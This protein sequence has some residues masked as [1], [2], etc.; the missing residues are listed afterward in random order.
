[1]PVMFTDRQFDRI[2]MTT[3]ELRKITK[4]IHGTQRITVAQR[5]QLVKIS[6]SLTDRLAEHQR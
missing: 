4:S 5:E 2:Q 1:M 3:R 6:R